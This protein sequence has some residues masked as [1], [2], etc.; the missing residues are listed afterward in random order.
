MRL[1]TLTALALLAAASPAPG[2]DKPQ[3]Q[4]AKAPAK[5]AGRTV[6]MTA[7]ADGF[8]PAR[9]EARKGEPL[10]LVIT[11]TADKTCATEIIIKEYGINQPLPLGKP[12]TVTFTP[13]RSGT[14]TYACAMDMVTG[15]LVVQ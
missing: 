5:P 10:T 6:T 7:T 12:V 1:A 4:P 2:A 3:P 15:V 13:T 8:E 9:I 11:R 14:V